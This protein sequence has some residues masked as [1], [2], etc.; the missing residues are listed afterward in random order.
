MTVEAIQV[1]QDLAIVM[2]I[3]LA[4]A[5][6]S[7]WTHQPFIIA[8]IIAGVIAGPYTPP[9]SL[10]LHPDILTIFAQ[11]GVVFLLLAV[12][13]EY[14]LAR[15]RSVGRQAIF[16]AL[17]ESLGTF[18]VGFFVGRAFGFPEFNS[19]FLGLGVSVTSTIILSKVLEELGVIQHQ[20]AGLVLGITIIEDVI[21]ISVLGTLQSVAAT[22]KISI[23]SASL[24]VALVVVFIGGALYVGSRT[25]PRLVDSLWKTRRTDLLLVGILGVAFGLAF[26]ANF[27]GLSVATGAFLAGVLVAESKSQGRALDLIAP[28]KELFGAIFFVSVGA[29]MDVELLPLYII[30]IVALLATAFTSK[31]VITYFSARIQKVD[32][33]AA[34]RTALSLSA[35]GGE[36]ALVVATAG[37]ESGVTAPFVLPMIGAMTIITTFLAPYVVRFARRGVTEAPTLEVPPGVGAGT[38]S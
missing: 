22:G 37:S 21:V 16:I 3:A 11:I 32:R 29:L 28:L 2:I 5:L 31:L 23:L 20:I 10:L 13:L 7:Y 30:P 12:G 1:L 19:L 27:I 15:L 18:V 26:L 17:S 6:I 34:R 38:E 25:V 4:M 24:S 33:L 8:Y 36:V 9:F 14:P 35:S